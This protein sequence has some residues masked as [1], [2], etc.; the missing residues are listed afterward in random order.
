M[1]FYTYDLLA[2]CAVGLKVDENDY[3]STPVLTKIKAEN[4]PASASLKNYCPKVGNQLDNLTSA[5]WAT[6][7]YAATMLHAKQSENMDEE[8]ISSE[9]FAPV[10]TQRAVQKEAVNCNDPISIKE[11][12]E[13]LADLGAPRLKDFPYFCPEDA[14]LPTQQPAISGYR[15]LFNAFDSDELK[16]QKV[17]TA[18]HQGLPVIIALQTNSSF[19]NPG[20][21][22]TPSKADKQSSKHHAICIIGFDD[23]QYGGSFEL[24]N[25]WG[26]DWG[27][28]GYTHV[29]F[30]HLIQRISEAY[31]PYIQ[32]NRQKFLLNIEVTTIHGS[33][34]PVQ[35][36]N[37]GFKFIK[38]YSSGHQFQFNI[39]TNFQGY[40]YLIYYNDRGEKGLLFPGNELAGSLLP[41]EFTSIALPGNNRYIQLDDQPG[42][43]TM[44]I[45]LSKDLLKTDELF[46]V[47]TEKNNT[48]L[49]F[50]PDQLR[51]EGKIDSINPSAFIPIKL[52]HI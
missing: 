51:I 9:S 34:M 49:I 41:F 25:S 48:T 13:V 46:E 42:I 40:M 16:I 23:I 44:V 30:Q 18:I 2:Q 37:T 35:A 21:V 36:E 19:C 14:E 31:V 50:D 8:V 39:N 7:Y 47:I 26:K 3:Y 24:L 17:K 5:G 52:N 10:F 6:A 11:S 45:V 22:W 20:K 28:N 4:L 43:E 1:L 27:I 29:P 15:R 33:L 32:S 38:N 12:L